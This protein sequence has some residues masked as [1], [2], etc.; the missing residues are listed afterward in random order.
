L[1]EQLLALP[2]AHLLVDGYNVTK[3]G[4]SGMPLDAQ[5]ARLVRE[6]AP[7]AARSGAEITVVFDGADISARPVVAPRGVRVI[8]S[9]A[10]ISADDV[11]RDLTRAEPVGRPVVVVSSDREIREAVVVAGAR[12]LPSATLLA[13][14][15][16]V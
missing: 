6:L 16:R 12:S 5:R 15:A 8:F 9:P 13:L 4:W 3:N 11:L 7:V 10:D 2:R 1:L 14:L